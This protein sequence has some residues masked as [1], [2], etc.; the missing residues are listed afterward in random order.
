MLL[1]ANEHACK[2]ELQVQLIARDEAGREHASEMPGTG[3]LNRY[4]DPYVQSFYAF[5][6]AAVTF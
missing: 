6:T 1:D 5:H 4:P 2:P 3:N